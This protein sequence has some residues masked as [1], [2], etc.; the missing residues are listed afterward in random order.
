VRALRA[1]MP[2]GVTWTEPA[3]GFFTW[4]R[5]PGV[6]TTELAVSARERDVAFVPGAAFFAE[7]V[8]HE[9]LRLSFSRI[10]EGDIDEGM[11]RLALAIRE[12]P[13]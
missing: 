11:R 9:Y 8:E 4:L 13:S 1:H 5:V 6:D 3:G 2:D 7:R 12:F 10:S